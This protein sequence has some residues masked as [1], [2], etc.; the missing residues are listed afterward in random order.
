MLLYLIEMDGLI[1]VYMY[2][3]QMSSPSESEESSEVMPDPDS[4]DDDFMVAYATLQCM[5]YRGSCATRKPRTIPIMIGIQWV[6]RQLQD[7]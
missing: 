3:V 7:D 5:V 1:F 2:V 6:E 4:S